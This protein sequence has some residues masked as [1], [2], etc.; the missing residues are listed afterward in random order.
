M[1]KRWLWGEQGEQKR[2][3]K[4]WQKLSVLWDMLTSERQVS[5]E[6]EN[7]KLQFTA[8]KIMRFCNTFVSEKK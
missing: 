5:F 3:V 2:N 6:F 4:D 7:L 8:C 1:F